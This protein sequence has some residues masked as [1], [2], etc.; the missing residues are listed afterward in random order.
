M[1]SIHIW[2]AICISI[3]PLDHYSGLLP[4]NCEEGQMTG[5]MT[6]ARDA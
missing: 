2:W 1:Q 3:P 4:Q 6:T 5:I